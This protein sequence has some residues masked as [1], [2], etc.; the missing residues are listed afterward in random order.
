MAQV[1]TLVPFVGAII[2]CITSVILAAVQFQD[3]LH[4]LL[5]LG[6]F[7]VVQAVEGLVISPRIMG[8]RVGLHP[9]AILIAVMTGTTLLGGVLGGILAI[10]LTA[11]LRVVMFRYIWKKRVPA[12]EFQSAAQAAS[13]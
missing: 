7:G 9:L 2:I 12:A 13:R 6:V 4:P 11:A 10:P 3:L 1:L 5:A 8:E